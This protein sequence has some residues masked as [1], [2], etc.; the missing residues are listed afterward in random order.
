MEGIQQPQRLWPAQVP[1]PSMQ[2]PSFRIHKAFELGVQRNFIIT[3]WGGLGDQVCAEPVLRH[4]LK[5]FD[6]CEI[7]LATET[8]DLFKHLP[9]K[10]VIPFSDVQ[11]P[12]P[13]HSQH[14][15]FHTIVP[16]ED[17]TWEFFSHCLVNA[18]DFASMCA[19]RLMLPI[20]EKNPILTHDQSDEIME[21]KFG[22]DF[23]RDVFVHAGRHWPSK[24]FPKAWWDQ[25]L[26][27]L[28][29][30]GYRPVLIGKDNHSESSGKT[31]TVDVATVGCKDLRNATSLNE[32]IYLLQKAQVLITNDSSPLH[33]ASTGNAW[34]G[35]IASCKHPDYIFHW[36]RPGYYSDGTPRPNIWAW[37]TENLSLDGI[38]NHID[39][40][41][42]QE[43]EVKVDVLP[44]GLMEALLPEPEVV[45]NWAAEKM[46]DYE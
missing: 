6:E 12:G 44:E 17:L 7:T 36:R 38:W 41:P 8:P 27:E 25:V 30:R 39:H 31:G 3:T 10:K 21:A 40:N 4:A 14:L 11:K 2:I 23:K 20:E 29:S 33:I 1:M 45:A 26:T 22:I 24:T 19:F 46:E 32:L 15:I 9:F 5:A 42:A 34:I 37:R 16:P 43:V 18:V 28:L 13:I 35:C